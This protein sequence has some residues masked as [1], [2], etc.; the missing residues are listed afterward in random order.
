MKNLLFLLVLTAP[1]SGF[2]QEALTLKQARERWNDLFIRTTEDGSVRPV[3]VGPDPAKDPREVQLLFGSLVAEKD[4]TLT[5]VAKRTEFERKA[6]Q[7][8]VDANGEKKVKKLDLPIRMEDQKGKTVLRLF[9]GEKDESAYSVHALGDKGLRMIPLTVI[10]YEANHEKSK[11]KAELEL[12]ELLMDI[13]E[14][15][16]TVYD[17]R[18]TTYSVEDAFAEKNVLTE[19]GKPQLDEAGKLRYKSFSAEEIAKLIEEG[20]LYENR[21]TVTSWSQLAP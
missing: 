13:S 4:G 7:I 19:N 10:L 16:L 3:V 12:T 9:A 14:A 6:G 15:G 8:V 2:A 18:G 11:T 17:I 5:F 21:K 20:T 1:F